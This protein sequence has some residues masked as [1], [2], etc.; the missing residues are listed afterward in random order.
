MYAL[1]VEMVR[2]AVSL[3]SN[4]ESSIGVRV[5]SLKLDPAAMLIEL[6]MVV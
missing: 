3:L 6:D 2:M 1:L 5:I 4:A